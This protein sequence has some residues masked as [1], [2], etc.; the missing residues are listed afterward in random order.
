MLRVLTL[1]LVV[2]VAGGASATIITVPVDQ[3]TIQQAINVANPYDTVLVYE[4]TYS[5]P[6]NCDIEFHGKK[7]VVLSASG[8]QTTIIDCQ[9]TK[10]KPHRAFWIHEMEDSTTV[11]DGFKIIN[12]YDKG[13][14]ACSTSVA[15]IKNCI[16]VGN[17]GP[18]IYCYQ[19]YGGT[20]PA[21]PMV[22]RGCTISSLFG[23]GIWVLNLPVRIDQCTILSSDSS[24]VYY[25]ATGQYSEFTH[26]VVR[27]NA[28]YGLFIGENVYG[29]AKVENVVSVG[30]LRG[31]YYFSDFPKLASPEEPQAESTVIRNNIV[32]FNLQQGIYTSSEPTSTVGACNDAY[33]NGGGNFVRTSFSAGDALGNISTAPAF[34]DAYFGDYHV[35]QTSKCAPANNSGHVFMGAFDVPC[36]CCR[37]YTGDVD[38]DGRTDISDM[39]EMADYLYFMGVIKGC[40]DEADIDHNGTIDTSDAVRLVDYLFFGL[41]LPSCL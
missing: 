18:G 37:G 17:I 29:G 13:A 27:D 39:I 7:V 15:T 35:S 31:I 8:P 26:L 14:I 21:T 32:V 22:I 16:I 4:G 19:P 33:G 25:Y 38:G 12:A 40:F 36:S 34:C 41:P 3:Y 23:H 10:S 20:L 24:G 6:G 28:Q 9:G 30:N 5:G 1:L 11:I 2:G